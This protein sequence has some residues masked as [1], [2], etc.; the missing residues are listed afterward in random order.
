MSVTFFNVNR[1]KEPS[2]MFR[3]YLNWRLTAMLPTLRQE[4]LDSLE[5]EVA[6]ARENLAEI[7]AKGRG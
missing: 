1:A 4:W 3:R 6:T 5:K 2:D 7:Q